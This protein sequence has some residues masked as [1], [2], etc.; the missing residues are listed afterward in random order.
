MTPVE[1]QKALVRLGFDAGPADGKLGP[2]TTAAVR[3]FQRRYKLKADGSPGPI[4]QSALRQALAGLKTESATPTAPG[5]SVVLDARSE[6]NLK[7]VHP[8][9]VRVVRGAATI[10]PIA[11]VV[12]EGLRTI[13]RQRSLV[14]SGASRTMK[15]RHLT[16]HAVDLAARVN[17]EIRWD[18]PLYQTLSKAMK[19]AAQ[20]ANVALEWG[21]DWRSF[22]DGP[23]FQLPWAKY[24]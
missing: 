20:E 15:S 14:A 11:F 1:I 8:D 17:G 22:K 16:G 2:R 7:G 18:W 9:L 3:E 12:T 23:H 6:K 13:E 24:P 21:G 4:T 19:Q 10:S 5:A